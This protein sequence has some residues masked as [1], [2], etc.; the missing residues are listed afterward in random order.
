MCERERRN[1]GLQEALAHLEPW[2]ASSLGHLGLIKPRR[3]VERGGVRVADED[4]LRGPRGRHC[5]QRRAGDH[6][7]QRGSPV[8]DQLICS[9]G[10]RGN[11]IN[12]A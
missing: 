8:M 7:R 4:R 12:N 1:L 11:A 2:S 5:L 10:Y 3:R 6:H 9:R